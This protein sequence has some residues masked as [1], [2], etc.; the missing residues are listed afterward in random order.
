MFLDIIGNAST[1]EH[2]DAGQSIFR[3]GDSVD[4][5]YVIEEG[6][7]DIVVDNEIVETVGRGGILGEMAMINVDTA[8]SGAVARTDCNLLPINRGYFALLLRRRLDFA[9]E[10][11]RVVANRPRSVYGSRTRLVPLSI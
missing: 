2:F 7:V 6:E 4:A 11:M 10:I 9:I 5:M 3:Q 8:A 1:H